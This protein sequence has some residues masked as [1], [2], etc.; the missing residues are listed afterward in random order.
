MPDFVAVASTLPPDLGVLKRNL[1]LFDRLQVANLA[2]Q[3]LLYRRH[4]DL[5]NELYWLTRNGLILDTADPTAEWRKDWHAGP[6]QREVLAFF[7]A[8][9]VER[10]SIQHP[11]RRGNRD[12]SLQVAALEELKKQVIARLAAVQW[13]ASGRADAVVLPSSLDSFARQGAVSV[14]DLLPPALTDSFPAIRSLLCE[15]QKDTVAE[16]TLARFPIPDELTAWENIVMFRQDPDSARKFLGLKAWINDVAKGTL[17]KVEL[18]DLLEHN[19]AEFEHHM[20]LHRIKHSRGILRILLTTSAG[21]LEE[22]VHL[23]FR[24]ALDVVFEASA[25]RLALMEAEASAP[26]RALAYV[27][28]ARRHFGQRL[29]SGLPRGT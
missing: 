13:R 25:H 17:T 8:L 16:I 15:A 23:R 7:D 19:L 2:E 28:K 6:L 24:K 5:L 26:G 22:L 18:Q 27:V 29:L 21:L 12:T 9:S 4:P 11:L 3:K 14:F 20:S 10:T 1:I